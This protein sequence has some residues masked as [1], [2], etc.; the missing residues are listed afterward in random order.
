ME[1]NN[2]MM[3]KNVEYND[4]PSITGHLQWQKFSNPSWKP[5]LGLH[6]PFQLIMSPFYS[7]SSWIYEILAYSLPKRCDMNDIK[8]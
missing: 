2:E 4:S 6:V 5:V 1:V 3:T 7:I 8:T